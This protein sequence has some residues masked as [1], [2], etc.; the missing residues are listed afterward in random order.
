MIDII[1]TIV[2]GALRHHPN[3]RIAKQSSEDSD[4]NVVVILF[5]IDQLLCDDIVYLK[6]GTIIDLRIYY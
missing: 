6:K 1:I 2:R 4:Q 5:W 3:P